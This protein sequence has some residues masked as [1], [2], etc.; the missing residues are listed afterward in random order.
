MKD[1][2]ALYCRLSVEDDNL[3]E[4][5]ISESIKNQKLLLKDYA[6]KQDWNIYDIY[7]DED[8]KGFDRSRPEFKRLLKDAEKGYFNIVLCKHQSRFTRDIELVEKYIN[9]RFILWGIRFVSIVDN[10]DT[11]VKGNKKARQINALINEWY[12][13]DLSDN[14]RATFRKKMEEGQFL[15]S[16]ACYGYKK[17]DED[18]H[19]LVIDLEAA[20]VVKEIYELY[21]SGQGASKIANIL[22]LKKIP[23]PAQYKKLKDMKY[24][25]PSSHIISEKYGIWNPGTVKRILANEAYIGKLIQGRERKLSYKS[26][27]IVKAPK[28]E[29]IIIPNNHSPIIDKKTFETVRRIAQS[30][31]RTCKTKETVIN[32]PNIFSGKLKCQECGSNMQRNGITRDNTTYYYRCGLSART[33]GEKCSSHSIRQDKVEYLVLSKIQSLINQC[34]SDSSN[35]NYI[36]KNTLLTLNNNKTNP[37]NIKKE[38][39]QLTK[40]INDISITITKAYADKLKGNISEEEFKLYKNILNEEKQ[41]YENKIKVLTEQLEKIE[42]YLNEMTQEDNLVDKYK[43]IKTLSYDIV[44]D[45]IHTIEVGEVKNNKEQEIIIN[46]NF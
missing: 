5:G 24:S 2:V 21:I 32:K 37:N 10:V 35:Y 28:S 42:G 1:R 20:E 6:I 3:E 36:L 29:W 26:K 30:K 18:K 45:F 34:L 7:C 11:N 4:G 43:S 41:G 27:K 17:S 31:R 22:T 25:N 12:S 39:A 13:E 14:I 44:N 40:N 9:G 8:L 16:F 23:T 15:G 38:I 46:W 33:K 19:K